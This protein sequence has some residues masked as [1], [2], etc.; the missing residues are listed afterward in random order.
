[1]RG[2]DGVKEELLGICDLCELGKIALHPYNQ[3]PAAHHR[4][5]PLDLVAIDL[6]GQI[7][8]KRWGGERYDMVLIDTYN[9]S[10]VK[11]L[12][13]K[14]DAAEVLRRWIPMMENQC[15]RKLRRL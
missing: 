12:A 7:V 3:F 14:S 6:A 9:R 13:K 4:Q 8:R 11:L 5:Y 10:W 2:I 15:G 1:M